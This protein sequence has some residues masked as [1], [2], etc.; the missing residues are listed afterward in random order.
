M[1]NFNYYMAS[2]KTRNEITNEVFKEHNFNPDNYDSKSEEKRVRD[3]LIK[4]VNERYDSQ[5]QKEIELYNEFKHD[6]FEEL[7]I[8]D[9]PKRDLLFEKSW[10]RG[11]SYGLYEVYNTALDLVELIK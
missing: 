11:H 8:T 10:D 6:L 5:K 7:E 3:T 9:N 4:I 1:K 2:Y